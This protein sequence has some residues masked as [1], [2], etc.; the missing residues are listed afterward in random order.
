MWRIGQQTE[1]YYKS[2]ISSFLTDETKFN[3]FKQDKVY[4][5]IIGAPTYHQSIQYYKEIMNHPNIFANFIRFMEAD[6]IGN[7]FLYQYDNHLISLNLIRYINTLCLFDNGF[8]SDLTGKTIRE[9]G[10]GFGGLAHCILTQYPQVKSYTV[11]DLSEPMAL[12][13][14]HSA[15]LG[16]NVQASPVRNPDLAIAE[17]SITEQD[18]QGLFELTDAY[19]MDAKAI[20]VRCNIIDTALK[21]KWLNH[22]MT[23]YFLTIEKEKPNEVSINTIVKGS[24][25]Q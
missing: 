14:K 22:L 11:V 6:K 1:N 19:L 16:H 15:L 10:C 21:A 20:F 13:C 12:G 17:Y 18:Q 4:S 24:I 9:I 25:R 8:I 5:S 3:N 7:P 2:L 23:R